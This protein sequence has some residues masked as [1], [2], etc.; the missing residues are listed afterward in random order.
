M[1]TLFVGLFVLLLSSC[2]TVEKN[3]ANRF[4]EVGDRE[5]LVTVYL[6]RTYSWVGRLRSVT[7]HVNGAPAAEFP[8]ESYTVLYLKPGE[9][10]FLIKRDILGGGDDVRNTISIRPGRQVYVKYDRSYRE[11]NRVMLGGYVTSEYN[12][13]YE[14][15]ISEHP[16]VALGQ[17]SSLYR[18]TPLKEVF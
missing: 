13:N 16:Q 14:R 5:G 7:V 11:S 15:F 9:Y 17:L 8:D 18:V 4:K 10:E 2:A 6:Y 12:T 3:E 1:K